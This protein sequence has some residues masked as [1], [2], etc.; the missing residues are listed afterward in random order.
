MRPD[1]LEVL[2]EKVGNTFH[3]TE[4]GK[5]FDSKSDCM[6]NQTSHQQMVAQKTRK[7]QTAK[8]TEVE[9]ESVHHQMGEN[10]CQLFIQ[11][12][13]GAWNMKVLISC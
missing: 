4:T 1:T 12:K 6:E 9:E 3:L 2:E 8:E 11:Q 5:D 10:L 13:L 7:L